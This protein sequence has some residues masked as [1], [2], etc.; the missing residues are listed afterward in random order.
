MVR[1]L[2][3]AAGSRG[4][5][6]LPLVVGIVLGLGRLWRDGGWM[7]PGWH[8]AGFDAREHLQS[9][10][11]AAHHVEVGFPIFRAATWPWAAG[12]L[13]ERFGYVTAAQ[14]LSSAGVLGIVVGAG[15]LARA[16]GGAWS[17]GT[18]ALLVSAA[19]PLL[20]ASRWTTPY[21]SVAGLVALCLGAGAIAARSGSAVAAG[22]A[23]LLGGVA[24]AADDR[25]LL[26]VAGALLA[27]LTGLLQVP[28]RARGA[29]L[30]LALAL[31]AVGP[32][33]ESRVAV[34]PQAPLEWRM[35]M[36]RSNDL[37][38]I[39]GS[40]RAALAAA[41]REEPREATPTLA[42]LRRPCGTAFRETNLLALMA[43]VPV[44]PAWLL[45]CAAICLL[46]AR[47]WRSAPLASAAL[48]G[49]TLA[50]LGL[51]VHWLNLSDRYVLSS[52]VVLAALPPVAAAR[53]AS[54]APG[55]LAAPAAGVGCLVVLAVL[56]RHG[57]P[58]APR[59]EAADDPR[60]WAIVSELRARV[61]RE[62][63][64]L[65]CS[66]RG[67]ASALLPDLHG[68][69]AAQL[70]MTDY[71]PCA[72][73]VEEAPAEAWV[74]TGSICAAGPGCTS[75]EDYV[76]PPLSMACRRSAA[77]GCAGL[78]SAGLVRLGWVREVRTPGASSC[79]EAAALWR[80]LSVAAP[81][82]APAAPATTPAGPVTA[83]AGS[84]P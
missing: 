19:P 3:S 74:V 35:K 49:P 54:W 13:G 76:A 81:A 43:L 10:W 8:P 65:D 69:T 14:V 72:R 67:F 17:G 34:V 56:G 71:R 62:A 38:A 4:L 16:L 25:A 50:G 51:L 53:L 83:P 79:T 77:E 70:S 41:C 31:A 28:S 82:T 59:G 36:Q 52:L 73:W 48:V 11:L 24:T 1:K 15:L 7:Q 12:T 26:P 64:L 46:P 9:A 33:L 39:E 2:L 61:P 84:P 40:G 29:L 22:L 32:A 58:P 42:A 78:D 47:R 45:A 63:P 30:V 66:G 60:S 5:R 18:A 44:P 55:R 57:L 20:L 80:R 21:P 6:E 27:A 68:Q 75:C 37:R 23:A